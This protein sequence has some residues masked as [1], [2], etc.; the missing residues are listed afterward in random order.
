MKRE[1]CEGCIFID[2][3]QFGWKTSCRENGQTENS[4][5]CVCKTKKESVSW[6]E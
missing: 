6:T 3:H 5:S 1:T 4:E 2:D